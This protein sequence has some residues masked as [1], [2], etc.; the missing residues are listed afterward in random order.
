[1]RNG[2][3]S[4]S[5]PRTHP[6]TSFH[7]LVPRKWLDVL[8]IEWRDN[9]DSWQERRCWRKSWVVVMKRSCRSMVVIG[10]ADGYLHPMSSSCS[11]VFSII[12]SCSK[13][14]TVK[15][16]EY[17]L[18]NLTRWWYQRV[19]WKSDES[20][21]W[22]LTDKNH[23]FFLIGQTAQPMAIFL[24]CG[25]NTSCVLKPEHNKIFYDITL[26]YA[27]NLEVSHAMSRLQHYYKTR[28]TMTMP[29]LPWYSKSSLKFCEVNA[30]IDH[31]LW[32]VP[33]KV[34]H[35]TCHF[36]GCNTIVTHRLGRKNHR[37]GHHFPH[38]ITL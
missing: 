10:M 17:T 33:I 18:Y 31:F 2:H 9:D 32:E 14:F 5:R 15:L 21:V 24:G 7:A 13:Q 16:H 27:S 22:W 37:L 29:H 3:R 28:Q 11:R 35:V 25:R 34:V 38:R 20:C 23:V 26:W 1:M 8:H 4:Q 6:L 12:I 30:L 19:L 36:I